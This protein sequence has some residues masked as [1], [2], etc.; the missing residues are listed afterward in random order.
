MQLRQ[1]MPAPEDDLSFDEAETVDND[2]GPDQELMNEGKFKPGSSGR[3]R[4][5]WIM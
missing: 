5:K 4:G 2:D 1:T 3:L